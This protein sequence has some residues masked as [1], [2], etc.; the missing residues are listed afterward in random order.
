MHRHVAAVAV[1]ERLARARGAFIT[2]FAAYVECWVLFYAKQRWGA[3][4]CALALAFPP[5]AA[6]TA[7]ELTSSSPSSPESTARSS[8]TRERCDL[9][10]LV[11]GVQLERRCAS[12]CHA[13]VIL[14][15]SASRNEPPLPM[16]RSSG[17]S[18]DM[19]P[20]WRQDAIDHQRGPKSKILRNKAHTAWM[21]LF[22][23]LHRTISP[24]TL[25]APSR[26]PWT[27]SPPACTFFERVRLTANFAIV[28]AD[29]DLRKRPSTTDRHAAAVLFLCCSFSSKYRG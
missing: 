1:Q 19:Q 2:C 16:I 11:S 8:W 25:L 27:S 22:A 26:A 5:A 20:R 29:Y 3:V 9:V 15:V 18:K 23:P 12:I 6:S 14:L 17:P 24:A 21:V 4:A 7:A 13:P 28:G 10:D